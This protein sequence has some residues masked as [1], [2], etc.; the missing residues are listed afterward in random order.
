M[1]GNVVRPPR[2]SHCAI[3]NSCFLRLDHHC[4]WLGTCVALHNYKYFFLFLMHAFLLSVYDAVLC[5]AHIA[6]AGDE[7]RWGQAAY[8]WIA[9]AIS[10]VG[11]LFVGHLFCLHVWLVSENV[12]TKEV[13]NERYVKVTRPN[14][15]VR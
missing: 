12:T 13:I 5:V 6:T 11:V 4:P 14:P 15:F 2:A 10:G 9:L 8:S 3:C 7:G 1:V